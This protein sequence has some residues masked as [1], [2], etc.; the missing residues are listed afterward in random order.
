MKIFCHFSIN[1]KGINMQENKIKEIAECIAN[2]FLKSKNNYFDI[3][4]EDLSSDDS[5]LLS[6]YICKILNIEFKKIKREIGKLADL[7]NKTRPTD[8]YIMVS[9]KN[10]ELNVNNPEICYE[11]INKGIYP[12]K[13]KLPL[14]DPFIDGRG[15]IQNLWYFNDKN[16]ITIITSKKDSERASHYHKDDFHASFVVSGCIKYTDA[17]IDSNGSINK[18][19]IKNYEFK[20]GDMFLSPPNKWHKMEFLEDTTFIT[21]NGIQKSHENYEESIVRMENISDLSCDLRG[22]FIP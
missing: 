4:S 17:D 9:I 21:I 2:K 11:L 15:I 16:S 7:G 5:E 8:T 19:T 22:R 10:S 20:T 12:D 6:K 18:N 14:P 1:N 3:L 13:V